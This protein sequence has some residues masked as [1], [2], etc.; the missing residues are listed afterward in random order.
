MKIA[1][2]LALAT[3]L[4]TGILLPV[5]AYDSL[6][7]RL[8]TIAGWFDAGRVVWVA[9]DDPVR[10]GYPMG[11]EAVGA[12]L[13]AAFQSFRWTT[14]PSVFFV[15]GGV[16]ALYH[17]VRSTGIRKSFAELAAAALALVP[18][19]LLNA[20]SGYV[21]AAFGA[22]TIALFALASELAFSEGEVGL[23]L[24]T[25]LVVSHV[26]CLKGT[27][28]PLVGLTCL[29]VFGVRALR[30]AKPFSG[31]VL[32]TLVAV[33]GAFWFLRNMLHEG[34]P[35]WPIR[36]D[37]AGHT[38]LPGTGSVNDLLDA[39]HNTPK[40]LRPF[41][42]ARRIAFT[43][44]Q[45]TGAATT[46]DD[47]YAGLGWAWPFAAVPALFT[48]LSRRARGTLGPAVCGPALF[49]LALTA[50]G[51]ALQPMRWWP[52]YTV[53]LWG[54][55]A[56][57]LALTAECWVR[58]GHARAL[59]V[60]VV[61]LALI[62]V[63]EG[64]HAAFYANGLNAA[65]RRLGPWQAVAS[66]DPRGAPNAEWWVDPDFWRHGFDKEPLVCRGSRKAGSLN[67]V[68]D[69]VLAQI[70]PRPRIKVIADDDTDW[71]RV[72]DEWRRAGCPHLLLFAG[73][74]VLPAARA[75]GGVAIEPVIGARFVEKAGQGADLLF[76]IRDPS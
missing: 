74:P 48:L 73:S 32:L 64:T 39:A 8:P 55:G 28:L 69:G 42:E 49:V 68:A 2:G 58:W 43:W 21:D 46:Y 12:C 66:L 34:N 4:A 35:I 45:W 29:A 5:I 22:V 40:E 60:G 33:P 7:Y 30:G 6:S 25:G 16:L 54:A 41:G 56:F 53:W 38:L 11:H 17:A 47:R 14:S 57:A 50:V 59:A 62:S 18:V 27:G 23:V 44:L 37:F 1:A 52:R 65:V 36:L 72:R 31:W 71:S 76:A 51:F 10:N 63:L 70:T 67:Y 3:S 9:A 75:D 13:I 61:P 26:L 20:P 24:A 15:L 19:V